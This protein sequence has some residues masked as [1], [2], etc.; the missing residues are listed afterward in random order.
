VIEKLKLDA[1]TDL[2]TVP[3]ER[4]IDLGGHA[5]FDRT[6][7]SLPYFNLLQKIFPQFNW[8]ESRSASISQSQGFLSQLVKKWFQNEDVKENF[9]H[10]ELHF[11]SG[12]S[13]QLDIYLPSLRVAFEYHVILNSLKSLTLFVEG[14]APLPV[15]LLARLSR[16]STT[17]RC[18]KT[19]R[20]S[21]GRD[22]TD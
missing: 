20:V 17:Q 13:M 22:N 2:A 10:P 1:V 8:K 11:A 14:R 21:K 3:R 9:Q 18:R 5:L 4:I 7:I 6:R 16:E 12:R 19:G 15:P